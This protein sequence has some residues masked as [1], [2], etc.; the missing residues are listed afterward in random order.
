MSRHKKLVNNT[1]IPQ[2]KIEALARRFFPDILS[3]YE[4]EEGWREFN[5]W[6]EKHKND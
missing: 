5:E 1:N 2:E 6:K 4:N 3:F